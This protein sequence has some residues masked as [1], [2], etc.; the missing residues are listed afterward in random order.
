M[1]HTQNTTFNPAT[2]HNSLTLKGPHGFSPP[3]GV[4]AVKV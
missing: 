2:I 3:R 1:K 4:V